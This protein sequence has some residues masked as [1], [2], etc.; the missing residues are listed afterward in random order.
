MYIVCTYYCGVLLHQ[1]PTTY[2]YTIYRPRPGVE[3]RILPKPQGC[4]TLIYLVHYIVCWSTVTSYDS[5]GSLEW[6]TRATSFHLSRFSK[7]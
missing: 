2:T 3:R 6:D 4:S 5:D 7:F 1:P